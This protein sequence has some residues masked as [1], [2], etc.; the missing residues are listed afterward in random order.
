MYV[1]IYMYTH[2]YGGVLETS[3]GNRSQM[4][5]EQESKANI[6]HKMLSTCRKVFN[7]ISEQKKHV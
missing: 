3:K 4:K 7:I 6:S 5:N 1:H 2:T